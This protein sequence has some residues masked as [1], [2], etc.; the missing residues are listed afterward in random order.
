MISELYAVTVTCDVILAHNPKIEG[1]SKSKRKIK[2]K[3]KTNFIIFNSDKRFIKELVLAVPDLDKK[4][5]MEVDVSDYTSEE[6]L[7]IEYK[8]R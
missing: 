7:F 6:V 1:R 8:D 2:E 3:Y 5:R 4:M